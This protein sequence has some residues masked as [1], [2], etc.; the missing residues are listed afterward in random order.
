M[1][2]EKGRIT[3]SRFISLLT[4]I[5]IS[6]M[7]VF[8]MVVLLTQLQ[9][10]ITNLDESHIKREVQ[11][12]RTTV[13]NF[14]DARKTA[15]TDV[16]NQPLVI[17]S[18]L[19]PRENSE[20]IKDFLD[21]LMLLNKDYNLSLYDFQGQ[22]LYKESTR[23]IESVSENS[24]W[25]D[26]ILTG[27]RDYYIGTLEDNLFWWFIAVPIKY[28]N[29]VEG[30]LTAEIPMADIFDDSEI[31]NIPEDMKFELYSGET[32]VITIGENI[33]GLT[34]TD[35]ID[36]M[37]IKL[38]FT[39][40]NQE[41][42][43]M[44]RRLLVTLVG[45]ILFFIFATILLLVYAGKRYVALPV[46]EI[47]CMAMQ[48]ADGDRSNIELTHS[49]IEEL[50]SLKDQFIDMSNKIEDRENKLISAHKNLST[51]HDELKEAMSQLEDAQIQMIQQEKLASIGQLAAGVAHE[52]NNPIGFVTSNFDV[53]KDYFS[54]LIE[55]V[56]SIESDKIPDNVTFII[57]DLPELIS[58][59][60]EGLTRV[61]S[62]VKNLRDFSRVD[63]QQR[64]DY[65][66]NEGIKSTLIVARNEYKYVAEIETN[67]NELPV[68]SA[69]GSEIN[70][71]L[72]NLIVNA[73]HAIQSL[74]M[75]ELGLIKI[76]TY[77]DHEHIT[78][79]IEDNGPGIHESVIGRIF[80]PFFTT[81]EP[82]K[83]TGLGLN[84]AYNT[85]VN[86]HNGI[87]TAES[88]FSH[89]AKF[90]MKLPKE[91]DE[92]IIEDSMIDIEKAYQ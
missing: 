88:D 70:D 47:R 2:G 18:V 76:S 84:I 8:I 87:L 9:A 32:K 54:E 12:M 77:Q 28:G 29:S 4:S 74:N 83:G 45:A 38:V 53:L 27:E 19:H 92:E 67:F 60:Q 7:G 43:G 3:L 14:L 40:S 6:V 91:R 34:G 68:I 86:K 22:L 82:G 75:A 66:L 89:G 63:N 46:N 48:L 85:I 71:V 49:S 20:S 10:T 79:E 31:S 39:L 62:I 78:V 52:L 57:E 44:I 11:F 65:D 30:I 25:R 13:V 33:Q 24:K 5:P 80:D 41:A 55:H 17:Q 64:S 51:K 37:G 15:L 35:T 61:T 59:S 26:Q 36:E 81:K 73:T 90:I 23:S 56:E 69:K 42:S 1:S 72:L 21:S 50:H 58:D 16:A